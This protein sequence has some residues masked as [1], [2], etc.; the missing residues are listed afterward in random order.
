MHHRCFGL[1]GYFMAAVLEDASYYKGGFSPCFAVSTRHVRV[2][3]GITF[4][5]EPGTI[6]KLSGTI[7]NL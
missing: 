4:H 3:G 6:V 2:P 7:A 1:G 5:L